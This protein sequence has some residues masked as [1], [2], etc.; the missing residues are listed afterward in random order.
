M[1]RS[2]IHLA[3]SALLCLGVL[4]P[5]VEADTDRDPRAWQQRLE[6]EVPLPVPSL[7]VAPANPFASDLDSLPTLVGHQTPGRVDAVGRAVVAAYVDEEG[8]CLGAVPLEVPFPGM[9]AALVEGLEDAR[10][11]PA[12]QG[13]QARPSWSVVELRI[14][15]RI[16]E[17]EVLT[18][19]FALPDPN[20]PPV[21]IEPPAVRPSGQV[22]D[23]PFAEP[24]DLTAVASPRR[25]RVR[26]GRN[27]TEVSIQALVHITAEGRCDRFV[28]LLM[29]SGLDRW[30][31][32]FLASWTF[33]PAVAG[34]E[35]ADAWMVYT[36][37]L[38]LELGSLES[39]SFRVDPERTYAPPP[40]S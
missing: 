21:P 20:S 27:E 38:R 6:V 36:A 18:Q 3:T 24:E 17:S 31:S 15:G 1:S 28:P 40:A 14:E 19:E 2:R 12:R 11:E 33:E 26:A 29:D 30:F 13:A 7:E 10:F 22:R 32:G 8:D 23:A 35:P 39:E 16:R 4:Q 25:I 34:G 9:A 5:L 37:R